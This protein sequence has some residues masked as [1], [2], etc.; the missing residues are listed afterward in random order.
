MGLTAGCAVCHDHKFDPLS[1]KEFYELSAFFNNT[2][3]RAKDGN[4]YNTPPILAVPLAQDRTRF[5][6][7]EKELPVARTALAAR[8]K[9]AK[10]EF[11]TWVQSLTADQALAVRP[12]ETPLL[13]CQLTAPAAQAAQMDTTLPMEATSTDSSPK[14]LTRLKVDFP[15]YFLS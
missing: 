1:Q 5:R 15:I 13:R 11:H 12:Q 7:I 2:T 14:Q 4:V 8:K 3:Q 10:G 9:N 6:E